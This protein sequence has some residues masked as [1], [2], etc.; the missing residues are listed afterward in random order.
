MQLL[1]VQVG[2]VESFL[3]NSKEV[4]TAILKKPVEMPIYL[5]LQ[6]FSGD[7]QADLKNH[8]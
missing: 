3:F 7:E 4:T 2:K 6:N 1:S 5:G 8:G